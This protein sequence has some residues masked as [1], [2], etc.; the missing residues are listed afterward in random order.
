MRKYF[1]YETSSEEAGAEDACW[2]KAEIQQIDQYPWKNSQR[3]YVPVTQVRLLH[4]DIALFVRFDIWEENIRATYTQPNDPVCRDSCVE[5]FFCPDEADARYL[6]FEI[7]PLG[8]LLIGLGRSGNDIRYLTDSR[9]LFQIQTVRKENFWQAAFTIP[10]A[11]IKKYFNNISHTM[12]GNFMKCAD[13]SITPHHGCWNLIPTD[14]PMF[15]VPQF[16]GEIV[17]E[18]PGE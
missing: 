11:F 5:F 10:F 12:R 18:R 9:E 16:F 17:L 2:D 7:N 15:H 13:R 3:P 1:C 4:N 8:A 14:I 6:S